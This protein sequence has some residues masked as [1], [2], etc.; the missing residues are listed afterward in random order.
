MQRI[1]VVPILRPGTMQLAIIYRLC[2]LRTF[3]IEINFL[4]F[5]CFVRSGRLEDELDVDVV[6]MTALQ[7]S[8]WKFHFQLLLFLMFFSWNDA[9]I[10]VFSDSER[11]ER[12]FVGDDGVWN[13]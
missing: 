3:N 10:Y 13:F 8:N 5:I 9:S 6:A 2:E 7:Y 11:V 4:F 12:F 1:L